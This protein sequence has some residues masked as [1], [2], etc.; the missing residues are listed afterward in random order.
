MTTETVRPG[1]ASFDLR[2]AWASGAAALLLLAVVGS[3]GISPRLQDWGVVYW[4]LDY[5]D[6][7][8]RRGLVGQLFQAVFGRLSP[9]ALVPPVMALNL[10]CIAAIAASMVTLCG[11]T[12]G[13]LRGRDRLGFA[14]L[15]IWLF[16]SQ[17]WPTV[18]FNVGYLDTLV[19]LLALGASL[20][21]RRGWLI[22][23]GVFII[24][25]PFV[26]EYF[27]FL[28]PF[29][30]ASGLDET[31]PP[32]TL[33]LQPLDAPVTG[34]HPWTP[35]VLGALGIA[36]GLLV[37]AL[38]HADA[39]Y[40][41][42]APLPLKESL[43]QDL[44]NTTLSQGLLESMGPML[45]RFADEKPYAFAN[46]V[47]FL[48]PTLIACG[49]LVFWKAP[50]FSRVPLIQAATALFP[51]AAL[52]IAWDLSRLLVLTT[53]PAGILF[54]LAAERR[55]RTHP[56]APEEGQTPPAR[57]WALG[58]M[59]ASIVAA[60]AYACYPFTYTYFG[61]RPNFRYFPEPFHSRFVRSPL[62]P[63]LENP[64]GQLHRPFKPQDVTCDLS[65]A[66]GAGSCERLVRS[67]QMIYGPYLDIP[68]GD[69]RAQFQFRA[70]A[71]CANEIYVE[72]IDM[73]ARGTP[74]ISSTFRS[75]GSVVVNLDF[76]LREDLAR[77]GAIELRTL[78]SAGPACA[79]LEKVRVSRLAK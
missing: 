62:A 74:L 7:M 72:V 60:L 39:A 32:E 13:R 30:V 6:G 29:I 27:V 70:P 48:A 28:I 34:P 67:G 76:R 57:P 53:F 42:L 33:E 18:V 10:L 38:S 73:F 31:P 9:D 8:I 4:W 23:A 2:A 64:W 5:S 3:K 24:L 17:F 68:I 59:A 43:K 69:F 79:V 61:N 52:L 46:F 56:P 41:Q 12:M 66:P 65:P 58:L 77:R 63:V 25:G 75:G 50:R 71:D 44:L 47:F 37:V 11:M 40:A 22:P 55:S 26:H 51:V 49:G 19:L 45:H 21:M 20:A 35:F 14:A 54:L 15:A 1:P 16:V 36:S 78:Q